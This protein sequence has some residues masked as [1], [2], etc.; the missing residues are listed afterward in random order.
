MRYALLTVALSLAAC[1]FDEPDVV[2]DGVD[3]VQTDGDLAPD[4]TLAPAPPA[5]DEN[6]LDAPGGTLEPDATL[7]PSAPEPMQPER[8]LR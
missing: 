5:L 1:A 7:Q 3:P 8:A 6:A 4:A 2:L